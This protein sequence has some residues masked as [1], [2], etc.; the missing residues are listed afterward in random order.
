MHRVAANRG[1]PV[2]ECM[3][4]YDGAPLGTFVW[5]RGAR[6]LLWCQITDH[7]KGSASVPGSDTWRHLRA[8]L[9]EADYASSQWLCLDRDGPWRLCPVRILK[10][11]S[12]DE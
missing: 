6:G 7:S 3:V 1:M 8:N 12:A 10:G 4:A 5:V 9:I 11:I 2:S